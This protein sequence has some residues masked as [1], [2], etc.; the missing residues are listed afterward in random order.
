[1]SGTMTQEQI[2]WLADVFGVDAGAAAKKSTGASSGGGKTATVDTPSGPFV[3][4]AKHTNVEPVLTEIVKGYEEAEALEG[5]LVTAADELAALEEKYAAFEE[6]DLLPEINRTTD[7]TLKDQAGAARGAGI[8]DKGFA[9]FLDK[10]RNDLAIAKDNLQAATNDKAAQEK[11]EAAEAARRIGNELMAGP[12]ETFSKI[13]DFAYT[14]QGLVGDVQK[15]GKWPALVGKL[16]SFIGEQNAGAKEFLQKAASLEKEAMAL[17]LESIALK[18]KTAK[19]TLF[20][21]IKDLER[22]QGI[23]AEAAHDADTKTATRDGNYDKKAT[24]K[25][26]FSDMK[27]GMELAEQVRKMALDVSAKAHNAHILLIGMVRVHKD[28]E[29]WMADPGKGEHVLNQLKQE[30]HDMYTPADAKVAWCK[31]L[32]KRFA[33][34]YGQAGNAMA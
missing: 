21:T 20:N 15:P 19:T 34:M 23:V 6:G 1:M 14:L 4:Y 16:S 28:P 7:G 27:K 26:K 22:W 18:V 31:Q 25:F 8:V 17:Q 32:G 11:Q 24:G 33:D 10:L 30:L 29:A 3:Y 13:I 2:K 5:E 9:A 12:F